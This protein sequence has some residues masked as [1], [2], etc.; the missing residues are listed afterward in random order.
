MSINKVS[1]KNSIINPLSN[2][3]RINKIILFIFL[4]ITIVNINVT[5]FISFNLI[6]LKDFK[7]SIQVTQATLVIVAV[8]TF[9]LISNNWKR[10]RIYFKKNI[11][12]RI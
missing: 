2:V 9:V 7:Y 4:L 3:M 11:N 12:K 10:V 5:M 8:L 6:D 1:I